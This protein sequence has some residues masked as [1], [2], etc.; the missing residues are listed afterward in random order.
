MISSSTA[1]GSSVAG[2]E[3]RLFG[4]ASVRWDQVPI[5]FAKRSVTLAMLA[6]LILRHGRPVSREALAFTLFP[7]FEET[8][9]LA[10]LR[11]YL[12][13][14]SKALP[15]RDGD[16][17]LLVDAETVR[18]NDSAD[19]FIDVMSFER[20]GSAPET[21]AQA[22]ELYSGDLLAEVYDDWIVPERERLRARFFAILEEMLE[23]QRAAR[24]YRGAIATAKR[25]LAADPWREDTLRTLLALRYESGDSAGAIVE[26]EEFAKKVREELSAAPMPETLALRQAILRNAPIPGSLGSALVVDGSDARRTVAALPFVGRARELS[27]LQD[28]WGRATRGQRAFVLLSGEAGAGKTRLTAE[29]ARLVQAEGGRVLVGTT[30]APESTPYQAIAEALRFALPL[31]LDAQRPAAQRPEL[32]RILPEL[33]EEGALEASAREQS[34]EH[35]TARFFDALAHCVRTLATPRPLLLVLEDMHWA[36]QT[37]IEALR[38]LVRS[39]IRTPILIVATNREEETPPEHPLR[40]LVRSL[41][42]LPNVEE[43]SLE[44]LASADVVELVQR[45]DRL[46]DGGETLA[47]KLFEYSEGNALFL[48]EAIA[49]FSAEGGTLDAA[50]GGSIVRVIQARVEQLRAHARAVAEIAAVNGVGCSVALVRAV[51]NL[52]FTAVASG[53]DELLDR[54]IL[55]EAGPRTRYDYVFTHHLIASAIYD[56]IDADFREQRHLRIAR[57]LESDYRANSALPAREIGRHYEHGSDVARCAEWYFTAALQASSAYAYAD[58]DELATRALQNAQSEDLRRRALE[59]RERARGGRG[60]RNGQREDIESLERLAV[61]DSR[62]HFDV[63]LRRVLLARSLGDSESEGRHIDAMLA[64]AE[65]LGDEERAQALMQRATHAGLRSRPSEGFEPA[66]A[67]LEIYERVGDSRGKLECLCLLVDFA[68]N[69]GDLAASREYLAAMRESAGTL[70]DR[71]VQARALS[72]AAV[73]ALLRQD[74]RECFELTCDALALYLETNDVE[75]QA[76]SRGRMAVTAA[77]L[78]EYDTA[79]CEFDRALHAYT[80]IGNMRG[81]AATYTNRT[82]LLMRVGRFNEA[83]ESIERSNDLFEIAHEQRTV[84]ANLVNASFVKLQLGDAAAAKQLAETALS[85]AREIQFP[86]FEAAALAN[87]GNAERSLGEVEAAIEHMNAG[88]ALRRPIQEGRDFVDDLAD[89]TLCYLEAGHTA[90]AVQTAEELSAIAGVSLEGAFW[91]HYIWW[92]ISEGLRAGGEQARSYA[93]LANARDALASFA[94][95]ITDEKERG[96]FL[97]LPVSLRINDPH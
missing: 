33:R 59:V 41:H 57:I 26:F 13:L 49:D 11:R 92:A 67:A 72:V 79:L 95:N 21:Q 47:H 19:A 54:G 74:Y 40:A 43:V 25:I 32:A 5:K 53:F 3:I 2:L 23:R 96:A 30:A 68:A 61:A 56:G 82:L 12:Y 84:V 28:A 52:P 81:L 85:A 34:A 73:A 77:W 70:E 39:L 42:D 63:L 22:I 20:L 91:P 90:D 93:A 14:A 97:A 24:S 71:L 55:R 35:E 89:L 87:L 29:L 36:G 6:F 66:I 8:A 50:A 64:V 38:A 51:S 86:A 10:E 62:L 78:G 69:T 7:D 17:W 4:H 48:N 31:F 80:S 18:W 88:I 60:D 44:R 1:S 46:R 65:A 27:L 83:L 16:P 45:V 15:E 37:S 75:G 76:V 94:R 58:A 9:A